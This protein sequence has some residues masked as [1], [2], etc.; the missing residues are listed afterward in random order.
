MSEKRKI[1][2]KAL[3]EKGLTWNEL[4]EKTKL[5]KSTLQYHLNSLISEGI[6]K[7]QPTIYYI[8]DTFNVV[9]PTKDF[10]IAKDIKN[11]K[12]GRIKIIA[13]DYKKGKRK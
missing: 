1:I 6:V 13:L 4:L 9:R 7:K 8:P 5:P 11:V 12:G 2:I 3:I 10:I